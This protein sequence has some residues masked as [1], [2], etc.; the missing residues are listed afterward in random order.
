MSGT[1]PSIELDSWLQYTK[2]HE[3]LG[4]SRHD[5]LDTSAFAAGPSAGEAGLECLLLASKQ[6]LDRCLDTLAATDHKD[7][8]KWWASPKNEAASQQPFE[9]PQDPKT[10]TKY[11]KV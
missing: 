8:L 4:R 7:L 9:L 2:W 1:A 10:L 3:V 11:S 5:L 6:L